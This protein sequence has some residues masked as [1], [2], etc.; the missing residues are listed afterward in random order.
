MSHHEEFIEKIYINAVVHFYLGHAHLP[1]NQ[2]TEGKTK[3][4]A[5]AGIIAVPAT[6]THPCP[7]LTDP[8]KT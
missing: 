6:H 1:M 8:C 7:I 5:S 4:L 2:K 3:A